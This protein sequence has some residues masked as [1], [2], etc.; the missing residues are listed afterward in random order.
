MSASPDGVAGFA[1]AAPWAAEVVALL[2]IA[3]SVLPPIRRTLLAPD[4]TLRKTCAPRWTTD[5]ATDRQDGVL[6]RRYGAFGFVPGARRN[7]CATSAARDEALAGS[8]RLRHGG[9]VL[10]VRVAQ[11]LAGGRRRSRR[12]A[13]I[14]RRHDV[15]AAPGDDAVGRVQDIQTPRQAPADPQQVAEELQLRPGVGLLRRDVQ[16]DLVVDRKPGI[17]EREYARRRGVP[18]HRRPVRVAA[19]PVARRVRLGPV[20]RPELVAL[21]DERRAG[22]HQQQR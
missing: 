18:R 5:N 20:G 12:I 14:Q 13:Q 21:E 9:R 4:G 10:V 3:L 17:A 6:T 7:R 8:E 15:A 2:S 16:A 22:K 19:R 11:E 1:P